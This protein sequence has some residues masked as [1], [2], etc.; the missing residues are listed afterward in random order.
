MKVKARNQCSAVSG[1]EVLNIGMIPQLDCLSR[2][3]QHQHRQLNIFSRE[4]ML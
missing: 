2:Q 4:S 3:H 1:H